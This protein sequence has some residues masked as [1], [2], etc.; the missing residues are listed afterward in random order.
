MLRADAVAEL[1]GILSHAEAL[2]IDKDFCIISLADARFPALN[3]FSILERA[4]IMRM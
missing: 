3:T 1:R 4:L 2:N